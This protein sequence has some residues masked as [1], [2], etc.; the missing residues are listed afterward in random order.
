MICQIAVAFKVP[1]AAERH[2]YYIHIASI[3]WRPTDHVSRMCRAAREVLEMKAPKVPVII[4]VGLCVFQP[5]GLL[6]FIVLLDATYDS[7]F[8]L[9]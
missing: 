6:L 9:D 2:K 3:N 5:V 7:Q 4:N 1:T 8:R